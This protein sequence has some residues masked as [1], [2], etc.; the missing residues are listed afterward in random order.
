MPKT[1]L[2]VDDSEA[3]IRALEKS[4]RAFMAKY[5]FLYATT[6]AQALRLAAGTSIDLL[7][8]DVLIPEMSGPEIAA[9]LLKTHPSMRVIYLSG[10]LVMHKSVPFLAKPVL[11][12]DLVNAIAE[13]LGE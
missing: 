2:V 3:M 7:I 6:G 1:V 13:A 11:V 4:F 8:T 12:G 5:R 10:G 9:R